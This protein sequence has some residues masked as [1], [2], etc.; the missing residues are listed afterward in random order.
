[1]DVSAKTKE[2]PA[3]VTVQYDVP[4]SLADLTAKFGEGVIASNAKGAIVISLQAFV[5]RHIDKTQDEL[6]A[7]VADWKPD[8]RAAGPKKSALEKATEL[9]SG[10]TPEARAALLAQLSAGQ[11]A[12]TPAAD[13]APAEARSRR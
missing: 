5:R 2:H 6:N 1:M 3:I 4:D 9:L 8:T 10:M 12:A 11:T 13:P 7:L